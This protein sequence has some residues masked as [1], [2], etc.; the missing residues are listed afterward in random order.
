M[1]RIPGPLDA[2][3]ASLSNRRRVV[4]VIADNSGNRLSAGASAIETV[5]NHARDQQIENEVASA[6]MNLRRRLD[7]LRVD[8]ENEP[9]AN[10]DAGN[11]RDVDLASMWDERAQQV[12]EELSGGLTAPAARRVWDARADALLTQERGGIVQLQQRRV[13][14]G[15]RAGLMASI[16]QAQTTLVDENATPEARTG[17]MTTI[18]TMVRRAVARR[19]LAADDGERMIQSARANAAA[20]E[21]ERGMRGRAQG[22][23][24]RIWTESGGNFGLALEMARDIDEP[25]LRDM[26]EDRIATRASRARTAETEAEQEAMGRAYSVLEGGGSIESISRGDRDIITRAGMMDTLRNYVRSRAGGL[27]GES[28]TAM[29]RQSQLIHDRMMGVAADRDAARVFA[30]V[31]LGE[32][33]SAEDA[34]AL[35][36]P[37][38]TVIAHGMM[39]D[40]LNALV[41]RQRQLRG[42]APVSG[43]QTIL[44]QAF[45]RT[46]AVARR[47]A[48]AL[49]LNVQYSGSAQNRDAEE[50]RQRR[51]LFE[52]YIMFEVRAYVQTNNALP[53][54]ADMNRIATD[55]L[56]ESSSRGIFGR[57][58]DE[59]R[60]FEAGRDGQAR[61]VPWVNIPEWQR[62]R[63]IRVWAQRGNTEPPTRADIENMYMEDLAG[64]DGE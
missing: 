48:A 24:D 25:G 58:V 37:E 49:G 46:L 44:D 5:L 43:S 17:A 11:A 21:Q 28:W 39:P 45:T 56:R 41:N 63:L 18:E 1:P 4:Q 38:G 32:P 29:T 59:G 61:R 52:S 9:A 23:E 15:A 19:T 57:R 26:V 12:R 10:D 2:V 35:G 50:N 27:T 31:D 14:E 16:G 60:R 34:L 20:F 6:E 22:E 51:A 64:R 33:L 47:R 7:Q 36:V 40:D 42:E 3:P 62:E 13:V 8:L 54:D 55:A 30:R 53:S